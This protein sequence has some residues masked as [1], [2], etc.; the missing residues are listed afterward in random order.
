MIPIG[1][2]HLAEE[3]AIVPS[4]GPDWA[5]VQRESSL[6]TQP[7]LDT[8]PSITFWP[9]VL[10]TMKTTLKVSMTQDKKFAVPISM[11]PL[12]ST[13]YFFCPATVKLEELFLVSIMKQ[14]TT[15]VLQLKFDG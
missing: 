5:N 4:A 1:Y 10:R 8:N 2:A 15:S 7:R 11:K 9:S 3:F 6:I 14:F 12:Y 13:H